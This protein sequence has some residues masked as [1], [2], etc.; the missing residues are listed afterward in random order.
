MKKLIFI[1][2]LLLFGLCSVWSQTAREE[3]AANIEKA[4]GSYFA[5]TSEFVPQTKTPKG[6]KAFYISHYSRHGSR[7][8]TQDRHY[9]RVV[10]VFAKAHDQHALTELGEDTYKRLQEVM[11]EANLRGGDL[12][13]VGKQQHRDIAQRMFTSFPEVFKGNQHLCLRSTVALRCNM[14][15]V[16]FGDKLK[17]LNPN[18][19]MD[20]DTGYS[21]MTYMNYMTPE[22]KAFKD[23]ENGPWLE[24]FRKFKE[25]RYHPD[26]LMGI[27]FNDPE[28]VFKH[29]HPDNLMSGLFS[30]AIDMQD[31][32]A[33]VSFYDLFTMDEMYDLW[34]VDNVK[35]Y[36]QRA[37]YAGGNGVIP[38]AEKR[39]LT[40]ILDNAVA[41]IQ[42]GGKAADLRFGH[43]G[44]ISPLLAYMQINDFGAST[45]D[46]NEVHKY[47]RNYKAVPM[48]TNLQLIF[49]R[50]EKNPD[51]ILV[52]FLHNESEARIPVQTD[53]FPFYKWADVERFYRDLLN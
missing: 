22:G 43:D 6:Y 5:Y 49:F 29:V 2:S 13:T 26:R 8:L 28:Y 40:N 30:I 17:S 11:E 50:N 19:E 9:T 18:L 3:I 38:A 51:D 39:L 1:I 10:D 37:N 27:L 48:A 47:W 33:N 31:I 45:G 23:A 14:S 12:S 25:S 53:M 15:M 32:D 41:V 20:Y 46:L 36:I 35:C 4:G 21:F 42:K 16:S 44:N 24:E 34:E 7:Y 52:K